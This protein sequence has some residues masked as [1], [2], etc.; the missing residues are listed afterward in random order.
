M[1]TVGRWLTII[2]VVGTLALLAIVLYLLLEP[3]HRDDPDDARCVICQGPLDRD[4][5]LPAATRRPSPIGEGEGRWDAVAFPLAAAL[6]MC[7]PSPVG[8]GTGERLK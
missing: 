1:G 2:A 7:H 3:H 5:P 6:L 4:G 8:E